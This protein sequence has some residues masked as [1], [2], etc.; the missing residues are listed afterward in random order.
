MA[1]AGGL[2]TRGESDEN[3][4]KSVTPTV[5]L[6]DIVSSNLTNK[7]TRPPNPLTFIVIHQRTVFMCY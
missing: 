4:D 6:V 5:L 3:E 1:P 7:G 2:P